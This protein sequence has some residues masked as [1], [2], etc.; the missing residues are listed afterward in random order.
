[1]HEPPDENHDCAFWN[2]EN[3]KTGK[4]FDLTENPYR[5]IQPQ[6]YTSQLLADAQAR[7]AKLVDD[8][9]LPQPTEELYA[10]PAEPKFSYTE[11]Q[12]I[13]HSLYFA[14][15]GNFGDA[16]NLLVVPVKALTAQEWEEVVD[17]PDNERLDYVT[18]LLEIKENKA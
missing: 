17:C 12:V 7:V 18:Y 1:M 16:K 9:D 5:I 13:A 10:A 4:Q 11:E 2:C 15:D 14:E 6:C 8:L 3:W